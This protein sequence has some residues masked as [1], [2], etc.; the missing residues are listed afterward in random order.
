MRRRRQPTAAALRL[1]EL[2]LELGNPNCPLLIPRQRGLAGPSR[3]CDLV[4]PAGRTSLVDSGAKGSWARRPRRPD[5]PQG[6]DARA[7]RP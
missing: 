5:G 3:R 1:G 7:A 6:E 4:G 2:R